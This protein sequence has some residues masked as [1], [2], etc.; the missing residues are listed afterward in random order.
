MPK[1]IAICIILIIG[2][3]ILYT[4][5]KQIFLAIDSGDRVS[6]MV[7][8][9]AELQQ[10]NQELHEKIQ[11][12]EK[13]GFIEKIAR[14]NLNYAKSGETVVIISDGAIDKVLGAQ[15]QIEAVKVPNWQG[16]LNLFGMKI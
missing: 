6:R 14:N 15:K 9:V 8:E 4:L 2:G 5:V 3:F 12:T 13:Y 16:W 11:D 1:T 7:T 10:K